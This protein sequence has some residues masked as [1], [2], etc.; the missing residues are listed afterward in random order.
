MK[1][2]KKLAPATKSNTVGRLRVFGIKKIYVKKEK[3]ILKIKKNY[4]SMNE[5]KR[6]K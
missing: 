1:I 3:N 2:N 5:L 6:I 4:A